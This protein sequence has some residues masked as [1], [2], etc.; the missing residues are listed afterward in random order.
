M[1]DEDV[2]IDDVYN[3]HRA[4]VGKIVRRATDGLLGVDAKGN[5]KADKRRMS[6]LVD[7][8]SAYTDKVVGGG[9]F[10][11]GVFNPSAI[12]TDDSLWPTPSQWARDLS[13]WNERL[14]GYKAALAAAKDETGKASCLEIFPTVI[15]PLL[16]GWYQPGTPGIVNPA[17]QTIPDIVTP[18]MLGNQLI[19][20]RDWQFKRLRLLIDDI[21]ANAKKI[22]K[23]AAKGAQ[24]GGLII[25]AG[26]IIA[27]GIVIAKKL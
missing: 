26:L 3:L 14:L 2:T 9:V 27:G 12:M 4:D 17:V 15:E 8:L 5:C 7:G 16:L 24:L 11:S 18:F 23:K 21:V 25:G 6:K 20:F 13:A 19:E 10:A 1:A 22:A